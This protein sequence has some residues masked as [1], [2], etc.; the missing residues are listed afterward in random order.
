MEVQCFSGYNTIQMIFTNELFLLY[1]KGRCE[2]EKVA[3]HCRLGV[4]EFDARECR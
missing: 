1:I 2:I 3:F 4:P